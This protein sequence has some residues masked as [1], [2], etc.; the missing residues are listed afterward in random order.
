MGVVVLCQRSTD[1]A[2]GK[3]RLG[4]GEPALHVGLPQLGEPDSDGVDLVG[5]VV[6]SGR[7][8]RAGGQRAGGQNRRDVVD[9]V[10]RQLRPAANWARNRSASIQAARTAAITN[11][12]GRIH[13]NWL[14]VVVVW[15]HQCESAQILSLLGYFQALNTETVLVRCIPK[16]GE[17]IY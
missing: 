17:L 1:A 8:W 10:G 13:G 6:E 4:L 3:L 7:N 15:G 12:P 16:I 5:V 9:R 14:R 2:G 11:L